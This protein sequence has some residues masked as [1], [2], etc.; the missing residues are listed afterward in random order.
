VHGS[1]D[2]VSPDALGEA[3]TF[4]R[5]I[6][7]ATMHVIDEAGHM[8]LLSRPDAF[9]DALASFLAQTAAQTP[10]PSS[11]TSVDPE[12][13]HSALPDAAV[14]SF[15]GESRDRAFDVFGHTFR[16]VKP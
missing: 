6:P 8:P 12:S 5:E 9:A 15:A 7:G 2:A 3:T 16:A 11:A 10:S 13:L 4:A 14:A 1:L